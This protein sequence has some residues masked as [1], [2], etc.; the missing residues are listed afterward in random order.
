MNFLDTIRAAVA[1]VS[2]PDN[3]APT[4]PEPDSNWVSRLQSGL[5]PAQ[6]R[7][8]AS[9]LNRALVDLQDR[10]GPLS[11][12]LAILDM[13][14]GQQFEMQGPVL[15]DGLSRSKLARLAEI[16]TRFAAGAVTV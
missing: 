5:T 1:D 9:M 8:I 13:D 2:G 7:E 10:V 4:P 11:E 3:P 16:A 6:L 15:F 14:H 12:G